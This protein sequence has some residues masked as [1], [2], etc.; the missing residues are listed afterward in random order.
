LICGLIVGPASVSP[1]A[2]KPAGAGPSVTSF[3]TDGQGGIIVAVSL[4]GRGPFRMLLDTGSTHSAITAEV[5]DA[6]GARLVA[7]TMLATV[8]AQ[9]THAV[10]W[11]DE[12]QVGPVR[13]AG[14]LP[15]V[16]ARDP[17]PG[18]RTLDGVIGLD[19][20]ARLRYTIDFRERHISW[21]PA[22]VQSRSTR[23]LATF[24]LRLVFGRYVLDLPQQQ[25]R[26]RLVPDTGTAGLVLFGWPAELPVALGSGTQP[27]ELVTLNGREPVRQTELRELRIG[28]RTW[29]DVPTVVTA[30]HPAKDVG[31]DGLLPLHIFRRVTFDGVDRQLHLE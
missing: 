26:L 1:M 12:L 29:R 8:A 13:A 10:A 30:P 14:V 7:R 2:W 11:I 4:N 19:V 18:R 3:D 25:G 22:A 16:V 20:L 17:V 23:S 6:V 27:R 15:T 31:A 24:P 5:V 21:N 9:T 28:P